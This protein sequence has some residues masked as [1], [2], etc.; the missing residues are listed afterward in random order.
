MFAEIC[1]KGERQENR[2][3]TH[4]FFGK[5]DISPFSVMGGLSYG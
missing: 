1:G 3:E 5:W 2:V 4:Y